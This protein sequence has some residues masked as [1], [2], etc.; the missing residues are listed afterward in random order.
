MKCMKNVVIVALLVAMLSVVGAVRAADCAP[1]LVV[2]P[3]TLPFPVDPASINNRLL[4]GIVVDADTTLTQVLSACDTP[5]DPLV[6]TVTNMPS[7]MTFDSA[8]NTLSWTPSDVQTGTYYIDVNVV[9]QPDLNPSNPYAPG[10]ASLSD[11]G[12]IV[13]RVYRTNEPPVLLTL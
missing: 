9:D 7:G 11:D 8:T 5:G 3:G 6:F 1:P 13:V 12:T 4:G 10:T 2:D